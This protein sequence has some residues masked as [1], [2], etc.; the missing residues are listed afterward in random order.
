MSTNHNTSKHGSSIVDLAS[1]LLDRDWYQRFYE[2]LSSIEGEELFIH[3]VKHGFLEKRSP[4]VLFNSEEYE[5]INGL[6][7][8]ESI[9]PFLHYVTN[10][11]ALTYKP[12]I[13]FEPNYYNR[14]LQDLAS[15]VDE[16]LG[17]YKSCGWKSGLN[18]H[19][20][21]N[22]LYYLETN[23]IKLKEGQ[24]PLSHFL[25]TGQ[26]QNLSTTPLFNNENYL[27]SNE[28]VKGGGVHPL[29]HY[30]TYGY[31]ENRSWNTI[32]NRLSVDDQVSYRERGIKR[33]TDYLSQMILDKYFETTKLP[34]GLS[35]S[36]E[37]G[38]HEDYRAFLAS[39]DAPYVS[40]IITNYN[41]SAYLKDLFE[42]IDRQTYKNFEVIFVD[43]GSEDSS[44]E[45]AR[46]FG[47]KIIIN[48]Q[49]LGFTGSN[50]RGQKFARGEL[51][52]LLNNDTI[53]DEAWLESLV[54]RILTA[55]QIGAVC[56]KI[57]FKERF[58]SVT[59]TSNEP[60]A[61]PAGILVQQFAY[62]K[63]FLKWG[64]VNNNQ[65]LQATVFGEFEF[66]LEIYIP[67]TLLEYHVPI[68]TVGRIGKD[69]KVA[70]NGQKIPF[71]IQS[72]TGDTEE[73]SFRVSDNGFVQGFHVINNAGSSAGKEG[74]PYDR[75]FGE[76][77]TGQYNS[78]C[79]VDYFCGCSVLLRKEALE[80]K[81]LFIDEL[82]AY[83]EDSEL[84]VRLS[85]AGYD[86][87]Y[88][89]TSILYHYHSAT[90]IER[91][92]FWR[93][94]IS[95]NEILFRYI[96]GGSSR[97]KQFENAISHLNHLS[98]WYLTSPTATSEELVFS[99][100][101]PEIIAEL[102]HIRKL[103]DDKSVPR[104]EGK[105]IGIFN[106]Y[107]NTMGGGE[108]HALNVAACLAS[109]SVVE[110]ISTSEFSLDKIADYFGVDTSRFR[111]R[112]VTEM[113]SAITRQYDIFVNSCY[114]DTTVSQAK[115]SIYIVSFP[116]KEASRLFKHSY[117]FVPN[118]YYTKS[119]VEKYWGQCRTS[120]LYPLVDSAFSDVDLSFEKDRTIVSVGRF[121]SSGHI[122][123]QVEI[124][125]AFKR[126][127]IDN[128]MPGW[129]L[130]LIGSVNCL[131]YLE[132]VRLEAAGSNIE[133]VINAP[134]ERVVDSYKSA[135]IYIHASGFGRSEDEEPHLQEHFGM[136]V[137]QGICSGCYP[138][139][140]EAA[141]PAEIV[142][143]F[144]FGD[145][146]RSEEDML[147]AIRAAVTKVELGLGQNFW[148]AVKNAQELY[149]RSK[150]NEAILELVDCASLRTGISYSA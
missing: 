4:S 48:T 140:Y 24:D 100:S 147:T 14:Q 53:V 131:D 32:F 97:S 80:G 68:I 135:S 144:G 118:S 67:F 35:F 16:P 13:L 43:D 99:S 41:G 8:G 7:P 138:V 134:Y 123:N 73:L 18:P 2:D 128:H 82:F 20:L 89:P 17:H 61:V 112:V 77:D 129:K 145:F 121:A 37:Y 60:F 22:T 66:R 91:S 126:A 96:T 125:R 58:I 28:D 23:Q 10:L 133:I 88:E 44:V 84:S 114:G 122:K 116:H 139:V 12:N 52:A 110:L 40:I 104:T 78:V 30:L 101:T 92:A 143:T 148:D 90:T 98:N 34:F 6:E 76:R 119:W 141:G 9:H 42:S 137:A 113:N 108:A 15:E 86:I 5:K 27:S 142:K 107:W 102:Q 45:I 74:I 85:S 62:K 56:S 39:P 71:M 70:V 21:F 75:G 54:T 38:L 65:L 87:V 83:F 55:P 132:Q 105:R 109:L 130:V 149:G 103:I 95:R 1:R 146:F 46:N 72:K 81:M 124:V 150:F 19:P 63:Y 94:Q 33:N 36:E 57:R 49:R 93:R 50:N 120:V 3:F 59:L 47:C 111:T 51:I 25:E 64:Q 115:N 69:L 26:A 136:A 106:P 31:K 29:I 79:R 127:S 11:N 117:C